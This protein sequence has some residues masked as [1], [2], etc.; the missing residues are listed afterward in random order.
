MKLQDLK[1]K[2]FIF[3][4]ANEGINNPKL[5]LHLT[6]NSKEEFKALYEEVSEIK[7]TKLFT[8]DGGSKAY[9]FAYS[10]G[11]YTFYINYKA[12]SITTYETL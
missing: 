6:L 2:A 3:K 12:K 4:A 11:E 10:I 9:W 5:D 8:H 1:D 7:E